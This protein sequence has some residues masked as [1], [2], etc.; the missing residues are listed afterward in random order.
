[1]HMPAGVLAEPEEGTRSTEQE[2][3][4]RWY[5]MTWLVGPCNNSEHY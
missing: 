3:K 1:M 4:A 2:V 5:H